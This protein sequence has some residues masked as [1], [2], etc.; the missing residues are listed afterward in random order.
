[1]TFII[2]EG[3]G[4]LDSRQLPAI[5]LDEEIEFLGGEYDEEAATRADEGADS[6]DDLHAEH[7][8][9]EEEEVSE[10]DSLNELIAGIDPDDIEVIEE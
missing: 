10:D 5:S 2:D 6:D 1:M 9:V 7:D 3:E 8:E 4:P